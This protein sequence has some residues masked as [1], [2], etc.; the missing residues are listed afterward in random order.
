MPVA[1]ITVAYVNP[2]KEGQKKGSVKTE[3]GEYYGV[4]SDKLH[5]YA[6]GGQYT[7]EYDVDT[8]KG[9]DYKTITRIVSQAIQA[10]AAV[11]GVGGTRSSYTSRSSSTSEEMFVMGFMNRSYQGTG[12]VP[13][14]DVAYE[15][16]LG[17]R[18]AWVRAFETKLGPTPQKTL[19]DELNDEIP[20]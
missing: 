2:P 9:K 17:L 11:S 7:V 1:N 5:Q 14:E 18:S 3:S 8:Y 19:T 15:Q 10:G 4:W 13:T 20:F 6:K 12:I 16:L